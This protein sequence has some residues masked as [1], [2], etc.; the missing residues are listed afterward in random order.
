MGVHT[1]AEL[2]ARGVRPS[3]LTRILP[4]I[5]VDSDPSYLDRCIAL[6]RWKPAAVFSHSTAAWMWKL[7]DEPPV[8]EATIPPH[9]QVRAPDWVKLHRR[10]VDRSTRPGLPVVTPEQAMIDVAID[11]DQPAL[12]ALFDSAIGARVF[13]KRLALLVDNSP[14]RHGIQAVRRQLRTCCP[15]TRSEPERM[16]ARALTARGYQLEINAR[17]GR[18][19]GDLVCRRGRVVIEIDGREFHIASDVFTKDRVRQNWIIDDDW[20]VLRYSAAMVNARLD[21]VVEEIIAVVRKRRRSRRV[22]VAS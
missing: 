21:E 22:V 16:V 19:F 7:V 4:T 13:W 1:R 14:G 2:L 18:Y 6:D 11:M 12:E 15:L 10:V 5:Y 20:R 8:V 3:T 17:I 9:G